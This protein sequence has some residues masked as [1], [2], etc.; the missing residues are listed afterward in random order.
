MYKHLTIEQRYAL[1]GYL[2]SGKSIKQIAERIGVHRST[3]Y[4]EIKRNSTRSAQPPDRYKAANAHRYAR[5]RAYQRP[6]TKTTCPN[7]IRR[8]T[9]L[10]KHGWS[11]E[12]IS[13]TC[14][15]RGI[16]M[17]STEAIYLWLYEQKAANTKH[18]SLLTH[19]RRGHRRRRKRRLCKQPRVL[20]K[21]KKPIAQ[22][23]QIVAEQK[24]IGDLEADLM[25]C[26]N[27]YLLTITDRKTLF[28]LITKIPNK[29]AAT[30]EQAMLKTL[31][32]FK[33]SLYTLTSDNGT[34]FARH[35]AIAEALGIEWY[36]A[37][38]YRS[39]Q[40]GCNEN[41]NGLI[42]QYLKRDTDLNRLSE[43]DIKNIENKLNHR[44]RK[45]L[46]FIP[47]IKLFL[48]PSH[49]ALAG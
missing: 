27:G 17:L 45:K 46:N 22:R 4:R 41:Q 3:L 23:P 44:P 15:R 5:H 11:P 18:A 28:N 33:G 42:R 7:I 40:R 32:P 48:Q 2:Q 25:K 12:Q 35:A 49:V 29:E 8:I 1:E 13:K 24:R 37:D 9:W 19:L 47:P 31:Q 6:K 14:K 39:Q 34:E 36:F 26:K 20:I 21:D 10:L 38:P 30:I 43:Q 16:S